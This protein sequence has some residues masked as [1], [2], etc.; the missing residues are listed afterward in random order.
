MDK[1]VFSNNCSSVL[2][3]VF[4]I[5]LATKCALTFITVMCILL[6]VYFMKKYKKF[7]I[8]KIKQSIFAILILM[9]AS[10]IF[11]LYL[12]ILIYNE[13]Y[14]D[15]FLRSNIALLYQVIETFCCLSILFAETAVYELLI[16]INE[17][18]TLKHYDI[19][20]MCVSFFLEALLYVLTYLKNFDLYESLHLFSIIN[21]FLLRILLFYYLFLIFKEIKREF[22][23]K[24]NF[25]LKNTEMIN[26]VNKEDE[27]EFEDCF[28]YQRN[29]NKVK[30]LPTLR[31]ENEI[32][33]NECEAKET[34]NDLVN[35]SDKTHKEKSKKYSSFK[36]NKYEI[37]KLSDTSSDDDHNQPKIQK[38]KI[39]VK[40]D[41]HKGFDGI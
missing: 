26:I 14:F 4:Q 7:D 21:F 12:G 32:I 11:I 6:T 20:I 31:E 24:N 38:N 9:M 18:N 17:K 36:T 10:S 5:L 35:N 40:V 16:F 27:N 23:Y 8:Q 41:V 28:I 25:I 33:E 37:F 29:K 19:F 30:T 3:N 13:Y 22:L 15:V 1:K 39:E 2:C 34:N